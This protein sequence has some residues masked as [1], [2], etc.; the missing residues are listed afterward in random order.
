MKFIIIEDEP[1]AVKVIESYMGKHFPDFMCLANFDKIS[2]ASIFLKTTPVDFIF[3]DVQL[4]GELGIDIGK[5]LSKEELNFEIIFTTAYSGFALEAFA[6]CAID[7][8]LKP[9]K[10]DR[11]IEALSRVV[12]KNKITSEQLELLQQLSKTDVIERIILKNN[13]GQFPVFLDEIIYLKADNVY[14]EFHLVNRKR[15]VVSRPLKEYELLLSN[16]LFF[17]THRSYI[18]NTAQIE[19]ILQQ[20]ALMKNESIIPISRDKKK[21]L[22]QFIK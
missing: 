17:K 21:E 22:E 11:L 8:L 19:T 4:N 13:D 2:E 14:T 16:T 6:L 9:F 20:V 1:Q 10:E 15:I 5:Y 12:K 3:L 18:I 7:Y